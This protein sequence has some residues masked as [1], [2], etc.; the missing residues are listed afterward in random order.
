MKI[1]LASPFFNE[2][3]RENVKRATKILRDKGHDV[4]APVEH[5][6]DGA[7]TYSNQEWAKLVF[8]IDKQAIKKSNIVI[9]L[10][11]GHYSDSGTAW[12]CGYAFGI[13]KDVIL[14][15]LAEN[16]THSLM[17]IN[18]CQSVLNGFDELENCMM[19]FS[20][21]KNLINLDQK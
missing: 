1:Y 5:E 8:E 10:D 20:N 21:Y 19:K 6:I 3:E 11:Y 12:E 14:V 17:M 2:E 18:G 9:V 4:F 16:S 7:W 13:G 15:R